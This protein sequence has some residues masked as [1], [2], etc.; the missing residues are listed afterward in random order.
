ML[1]MPIIALTALG[2]STLLPKYQPSE[3]ELEERLEFCYFDK[4]TG[5][6]QR[7]DLWRGL[8]SAQLEMRKVPRKAIGDPLW[9]IERQR[10]M[11]RRRAK[12]AASMVGEME[13][14]SKA[15]G[16]KKSRDEEAPEVKRRRRQREKREKR[17]RERLQAAAERA[18][19]RRRESASSNTQD[20]ETASES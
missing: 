12:K 17:S 4:K 1:F 18:M 19:E 3:E 16:K 6:W 9:A 2:F 5:A 14:R 13:E 20:P 7:P 8:P 10:M 11:D 15:W